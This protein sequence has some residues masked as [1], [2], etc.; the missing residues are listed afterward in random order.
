MEK[1]MYRISGKN[2]LYYVWSAMPLNEIK[3]HA[4]DENV[5]LQRYMKDEYKSDATVSECS[6]EEPFT[7]RYRYQPIY[8]W[9]NAIDRY[10]LAYVQEMV[11]H[12]MDFIIEHGIKAE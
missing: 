12:K 10:N 2:F 3:S 4:E 11:V 9:K 1:K 5:K 7:F 6:M 8:E